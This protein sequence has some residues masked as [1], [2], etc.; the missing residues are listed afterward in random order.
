MSAASS[1]RFAAIQTETKATSTVSSM[2]VQTGCRTFNEH[3]VGVGGISAGRRWRQPQRLQR[4]QKP[5]LSRA[6]QCPLQMH[7]LDLGI[8][9]SEPL[10]GNQQICQSG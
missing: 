1:S 2:L 4:L 9:Q 8:V 3:L 7:I 6:T 10:E 5:E